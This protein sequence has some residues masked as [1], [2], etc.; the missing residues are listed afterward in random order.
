MPSSENKTARFFSS[1]SF[2]SFFFASADIFSQLI[3]RS[4]LIN[5]PDLSAKRSRKPRRCWPRSASG[6]LPLKP[7]S[8]RGWKRP[9]QGQDPAKGSR[10]KP[11]R[12]DKVI[13]SRGSEQVEVPRLEGRSLEMAAQMLKASGLRRGRI[14]Q[15]HGPESAGRS[16]P[17]IL[18]PAR[19]PPAPQP[20]ISWSA[21][22]GRRS[23]HHAGLHRSH[24]ESVSVGSGPRNSSNTWSITPGIRLG[25]ASS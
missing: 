13:V 17:R 6:S 15:I 1:S 24:A 20:W 25:P 5:L 8:I 22:Q 4:E 19:S 23:L 18:R 7:G 3:Y 2:L 16:S 21:G 10:I 11:R 14:S 9:I 12:T